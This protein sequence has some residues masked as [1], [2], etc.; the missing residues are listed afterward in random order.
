[1]PLRTPE[2]KSPLSGEGR[3][4]SSPAESDGVENLDDSRLTVGR[5]VSL[6]A[7]IPHAGADLMGDRREPLVDIASKRSRTYGTGGER[8]ESLPR[9]GPV[10]MREVALFRLKTCCVRMFGEICS[11][12]VSSVIES[13]FLVA[14]SM[15]G[16]RRGEGR[17]QKHES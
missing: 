7:M 17:V 13:P 12:Q 1:M 5:R 6:S 4:F 9:I 15:P 10:R 3:L 8:K 14:D 11:S 16:G 2:K